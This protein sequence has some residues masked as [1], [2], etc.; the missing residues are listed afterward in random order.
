ML[1]TQS[2]RATQGTLFPEAPYR[3]ALVVANPVAGRGQ[4]AAAGAEVVEGLK[5]RG[6]P[7]ELFL[8]ARRGDARA[9]LRCL[10]PEADLV[11]SVGG[12]G[13]LAEV[14]SG[15]LDPRI[16]IGIL[17][18]G[19]ANVMS[20]DL[21]LPRDVD[22]ALEVIFEQRYVLIDTYKVNGHLGFL[23]TGVGFDGMCVRELEAE[24]NGPISKWSY[25][26]AAARA[27]RNYRPPALSVEIDGRPVPGTFGLVL[28]SNIVHYAG[29]MRLAGGARLDDGMFEVYLFER[30]SRAALVPYA[31]RG[32]LGLLP[33][34]AC[35][36]QRARLVRVTAPE[37]VPYQVDGDYRGETP[38]DFAVHGTQYRL[39][40]PQRSRLEPSR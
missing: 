15:M 8:T 29:V 30:S 31:V 26:R 25:V 12:D 3:R 24:R 27:M 39:L 17:P 20:L 2:R 33:G 23:V 1:D 34:G 13:T 11:V 37:P 6:V 38:V 5:R 32:L 19:T 28:I 21:G 40:V 14:L 16:P 22:R 36:M 7:A 35:R 9:R 10:E 18:L 4:G